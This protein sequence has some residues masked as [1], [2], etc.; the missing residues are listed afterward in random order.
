MPQR[1]ATKECRKECDK[2]KGRVA[3]L[4]FVTAR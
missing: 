2:N 3:P 1:N 4:I